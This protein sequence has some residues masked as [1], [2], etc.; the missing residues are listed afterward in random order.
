MVRPGVLPPPGCQSSGRAG[1]APYLLRVI[2][3]G[4]V[5]VDALRAAIGLAAELVCFK[6]GEHQEAV[7][8]QDQYGRDDDVLPPHVDRPQSVAGAPNPGCPGRPGPNGRTL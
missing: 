6:S 1:A 2:R 3:A 4:V 7:N 8:A 5:A